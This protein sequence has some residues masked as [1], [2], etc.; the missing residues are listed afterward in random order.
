MCCWQTRFENIKSI[1]FDTFY[2]NAPTFHTTSGFIIVRED[3]LDL[4]KQFVSQSWLSRRFWKGKVTF[5]ENAPSEKFFNLIPKKAAPLFFR[6][7]DAGGFHVCLECQ[8]PTFARV[9]NAGF[10]KSDLIEQL[11]IYHTYLNLMIA[12]EDVVDAIKE[13]G[14]KRIEFE[15]VPIYDEPQDGLPA[16]LFQ[17]S[18]DLIEAR[19][20]KKDRTPRKNAVSKLAKL[21]LE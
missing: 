6:F 15:P 12:R 8:R 10:L 2:E 18:T 16:D 14:M 5:G 9:F 21:Q 17:F 11:P 1:E 20:L 19:L 13:S 7:K 3:L 4:F